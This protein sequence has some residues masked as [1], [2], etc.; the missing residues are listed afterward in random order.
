ML[1][2]CTSISF[3]PNGGSECAAGY[4]ACDDIKLSSSRIVVCRDELGGSVSPVRGWPDA[5]GYHL[6]LV[7]PNAIRHVGRLDEQIG[8]GHPI[9]IRIPEETT[10]VVKA[11]DGP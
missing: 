9:W 7:V 1:S 3:C 2:N 10:A 6:I 4:I 5:G 8:C 11:A